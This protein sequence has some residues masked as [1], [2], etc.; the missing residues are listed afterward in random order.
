VGE[1]PSIELVENLVSV[2]EDHITTEKA[3]QALLKRIIPGYT[4]S[5]QSM[6]FHAYLYDYLLQ[7]DSSPSIHHQLRRLR[8]EGNEDG[9]EV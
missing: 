3:R 1:E 8:E 7:Y 2:L 5:R 9:I 4:H 6:S